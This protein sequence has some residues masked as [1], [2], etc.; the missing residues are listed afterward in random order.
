MSAITRM[1]MSSGIPM[2]PNIGNSYGACIPGTLGTLGT[3]IPVG[4]GGRPG[5]ITGNLCEIRF[6]SIRM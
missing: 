6:Y 1:M 4:Q 5:K 3:M 2:E